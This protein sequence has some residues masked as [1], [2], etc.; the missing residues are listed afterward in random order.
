MTEDWLGILSTILIVL[1]FYFGL[2]FIQYLKLGD[3]RTIKQSK[4][5][6]DL[7]SCRRVVDSCVLTL[8]PF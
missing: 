1:G 4:F 6:A 2:T 8:N 7:L 3:E 5:A